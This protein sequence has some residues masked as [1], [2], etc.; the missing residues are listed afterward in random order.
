M[1]LGDARAVNWSE[2]ILTLLGRSRSTEATPG[3]RPC[4][5]GREAQG[6]Q[7][8]EQLLHIAARTP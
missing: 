8:Y 7:A 4:W 6:E 5:T 3:V 1:T 2:Q